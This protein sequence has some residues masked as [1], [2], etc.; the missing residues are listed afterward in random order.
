MEQDLTMTLPEKFRP[1]A[2][3]TTPLVVSYRVADS[4]NL[5]GM[6]DE[7]LRAAAEDTVLRPDKCRTHWMVTNSPEHAIEEGEE[8]S[9]VA[10][11]EFL[12]LLAS[13]K[14]DTFVYSMSD[15][16]YRQVDELV[17]SDAAK[18]GVRPE[19]VLVGSVRPALEGVNMAQVH[20]P[21]RN[22]VRIP[23]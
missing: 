4:G 12:G 22:A 23:I 20:W 17:R 7:F 18:A 21:L 6:D 11:L 5:L 2:K 3:V 15:G 10:A 9:P 14:D 1:A 8:I 13:L 16:L 19:E